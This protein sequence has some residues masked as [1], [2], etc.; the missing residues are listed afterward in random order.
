MSSL[1]LVCPIQLNSIPNPPSVPNGQT[2]GLSSRLSAQT[3]RSR[4]S[5]WRR[6]IYVRPPTCIFYQLDLWNVLISSS[7]FWNAAY[8]L[9][10]QKN[11]MKPTSLILTT[12]GCALRGAN[13]NFLKWSPEYEDKPWTPA[14]QTLGALVPAVQEAPKPTAAPRPRS[15]RELA[16]RSTDVCGYINGISCEQEFR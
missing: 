2:F 14:E 6:G 11:N 7:V 12:V 15:P 10:I 16:K 13:A 9:N 1:C 3:T 5:A 8:L 4:G